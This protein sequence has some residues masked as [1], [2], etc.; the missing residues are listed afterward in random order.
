MLLQQ[1]DYEIVRLE[2]RRHST[3][4]R[5]EEWKRNIFT[6]WKLRHGR[7][8]SIRILRLEGIRERE[9]IGL[10]AWLACRS[11]AR[12]AQG[13]VTT[14]AIDYQRWMIITE[15]EW[16]VMPN[17][18]CTLLQRTAPAVDE[19]NENRLAPTIKGI[20]T[21]KNR[22]ATRFIHRKWKSSTARKSPQI[23]IPPCRMSVYL[24]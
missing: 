15:K 9:R 1:I 4:R 21:I 6:R 22:L 17:A 2:A 12:P 23:Y 16:K 19:W 11:V 14:T 10:M 20:K 18:G 8:L 7:V 24:Y 3:I 13:T 5:S